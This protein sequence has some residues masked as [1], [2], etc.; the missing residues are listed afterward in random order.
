MATIYRMRQRTLSA[1]FLIGGCF[2]GV[3]FAQDAT[4]KSD[5]QESVGSHR[6]QVDVSARG[7]R[8]ALESLT[9]DDL[10]VQAGLKK[11]SSFTLDRLCPLDDATETP[12]A[13]VPTS[14]LLYFDQTQL[15]LN[16]RKRSI[17]IARELITQLSS[18]ESRMAIV[19]N[20]QE[21]QTVAGWSNDPTIL[22]ESLK[23]LEN[24]FTQFDSYPSQESSRVADIAEHLEVSRTVQ[25]AIARARTY[26][27]E[28]TWRARKSFQRIRSVLARFT[29]FDPPR[30]VILFSDTLRSNAGEHYTR[31]FSDALAVPGNP[32]STMKTDAGATQAA[33]DSLIQDLIT[34]GIRTY[35]IESSSFSNDFGAEISST[36][37]QALAAKSAPSSIGRTWD[38]RQT[39]DSLASETGGR[40]FAQNA[41]AR[42]I[43]KEIREDLECVFLIGFDADRF[44]ADTVHLLKIT[45]SDPRVKLSH[46]GLF[47]NTSEEARLRSRM[48]SA[49]VNPEDGKTGD[50]LPAY[51]IPL[52]FSEGR[53]RALLQIQFAG[54]P[55]ARTAWDLGASL[56][57]GERVLAERSRRVELDALGA[58]AAYETEISFK[59]GTIDLL[60]VARESTT[61]LILSGTTRQDWQ[62]P[63][64][65]RSPPVQI[66]QEKNAIIIRDEETRS[67]GLW[68]LGENDPLIGE[69]SAAFVGVACRGRSG[70]DG[71]SVERQIQ[72][73]SVVS[74][75]SVPLESKKDRCLQ[76]RDLV[77]PASLGA[78]D[79][80]YRLQV[81]H[82]GKVLHV[83]ER[84]F[85]VRDKL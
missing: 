27:K 57:G 71:W 16:G 36:S 79:Y 38:A 3:I 66:L 48:L 65:E 1:L 73:K 52:G 34:R 10:T 46:R 58:P 31:F 15:T 59:P 5:L 80:I 61:N 74:F 32:L 72:G 25:Q 14:Y 7:P 37:G 22:G 9:T 83:Q 50:R 18:T 67:Q 64:P 13:A 41:T 21:L 30:V 2:S 76:V 26:E 40:S 49:F 69:K 78:G 51:M 84:S 54:S 56:V 81:S 45:S 70:G 17:S 11:V 44:R 47:I 77:P 60:A 33:F 28:E 42:L 24:D 63:N 43:S 53:W 39:M 4:E 82:R 62:S 55:T 6:I 68:V 75:P 35:S 8:E 20:A 23:R 29:D 19:S 85:T 12:K